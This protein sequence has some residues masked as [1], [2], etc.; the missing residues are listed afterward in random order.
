MPTPPL[1]PCRSP[2]PAPAL[3]V[4]TVDD[5]AAYRRCLRELLAVDPALRLAGE[6][7]NAASALQAARACAPR[8]LADVVLLDVGLPDASGVALAGALRRL[9]PS[10]RILALSMHDDAA[11]VLAMRR[12]GAGGYLLKNDPLPEILAGVQ[13]VARGHCVLSAA[14]DPALWPEAQTSGHDAEALSANFPAAIGSPPM[15]GGNPAA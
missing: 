7:A 5:H 15:G 11:F 13:A 9:A 6:A 1:P 8:P 3:C 4:F 14:L 2:V 12:A 10:T